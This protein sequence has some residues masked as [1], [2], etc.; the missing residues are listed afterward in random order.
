MSKPDSKVRN[1]RTKLG[2]NQSAFWT[3]VGVTQSGGSR[4]EAGRSM[5]KAV[6]T[7]LDLAY[8]KKP[9]DTLAKLRGVEVSSLSS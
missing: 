3:R 2:L 4:Y 6:K 9:L 8:G 5:P 7:L 1:Q